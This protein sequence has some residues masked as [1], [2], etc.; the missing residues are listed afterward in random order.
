MAA[1]SPANL[2][3][4]LITIAAVALGPATAVRAAPKPTE[5]QLRAQ[6]KQLNAKVD[7]LI[8]QY[9]LKRVELAKA[10][11]AAAATERRLAA[12]EQALADTERRVAEIARLRY[13]NGDTS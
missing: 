2:A 5:A 3:I 7:K 4:G 13:Q 8:E 12:A 9:N 11:E 6:L 1:S 10:Q